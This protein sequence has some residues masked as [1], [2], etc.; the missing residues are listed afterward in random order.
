MGNWAEPAVEQAILRLLV[1]TVLS[2]LVGLERELHE[3]PAGFRTNVLV[4]LGSC[5]FMMISAALA[6]DKWDPARV[7]AN[8]VVGIGFLGAGTIIHQGSGVRGLTT[9]ATLWVVSAIG[10]AAGMGWFWGAALTTALVLLVLVLFRLAEPQLHT[11]PRLSLIIT[12]RGSSATVSSCCRALE[13]LG[14]FLQQLQ[15]Q[16]QA[17]ENRQTITA[18]LSLPSSLRPEAVLESLAAVEGVESV[19]RE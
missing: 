14:V 10:V 4:G 19:H 7:A 2:G 1:A 6:T 8:I 16:R 15:V 18:T 5:L 13:Q 11:R 9:A 17:D 12:A 3:R